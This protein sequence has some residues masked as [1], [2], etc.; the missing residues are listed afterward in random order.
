[1]NEIKR[2]K[3]QFQDGKI[4]KEAY[5]AALQS[6]LDGQDINQ[7][8]FDAAKEFDPATDDEKPIFTQ[9]DVNGMVSREVSTRIRGILKKAGVTV[10]VP[11]KGLADKLVELVKNGEGKSPDANDQELKKLRADAA[12]VPELESQL[13]KAAVENAVIQ[14]VGKYQPHNA[15]QVIRALNA[16]YSDLLQFDEDTGAL[17][18]GSVEKAVKRIAEVEPNLFQNPKG[19]VD[20]EDDDQGGQGGQGGAGFQG[21]PPGGGSGGGK[22]NKAE[23]IAAEGLKLMGL[24][25]TESK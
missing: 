19:D 9:E 8:E 4:T 12:R 2:L 11:N 16:D 25:K 7:E 23:A 17:K 20:N 21:R 13:K 5:L 22:G 3:K 14:A 18:R 1:M 15:Q 10:D 6:L 24:G